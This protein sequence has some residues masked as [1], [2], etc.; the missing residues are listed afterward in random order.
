MENEQQSILE[1]DIVKL[2]TSQ[3]KKV[4]TATA[5]KTRYKL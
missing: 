4:F 3:E 5:K 1:K 2:L